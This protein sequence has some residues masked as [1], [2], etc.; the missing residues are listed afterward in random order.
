MAQMKSRN[1]RNR[2]SE[3][4]TTEEGEFEYPEAF[5]ANW[6]GLPPKVFELRRKLYRKAKSEPKFRFYALYDR[7]YRRDVLAAAWAQVS[8]NGGAPGVDGISIE[9]LEQKEGGIENLL[10]EIEEALRT[11]SYQ[12]QA[13]RR[14]YIPKADG[15][16]RPLGIPTV[17][18]RIVQ[19]AVLLVIEPVFEADFEETSYGFRPKRSAKHALEAIKAELKKGRRQV[20]DADLKACFDTI[21]HQKLLKCLENRIADRS[22]SGLIRMWLGVEVVEEDQ[23]GRQNRSRQKRGTPQGGVISPLLANIYL[24]WLDKLFRMESGPRVWADARIVRYADDF[25]ILTSRKTEEIMEWL[26]RLL[27]GRM[28]LVINQQKTGIRNVRIEGEPLDFLGYT[29]RW[30]KWSREW[31]RRPWLSMKPSKKAQQRFREQVRELTQ[32][33][34]C[35][36]PIPTVVGR[37]NA[38]LRGWRQYFNQGNRGKVFNHANQYV[39]DR[40]V[41]HLKRRSQRHLRPPG[42]HSYY[43]FVYQRLGVARL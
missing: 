24:H 2:L 34:Y 21:D 28:G 6:K 16:H 36:T 30:E 23:N 7:V 13:I 18:D 38:Y 20:V 29:L 17:R 10:K 5:K 3:M 11:K 27:E 31:S 4:T 8:R 37:L 25:V 41:R 40:M 15:G 42:D 14:V 43:Q 19:M 33:R 32:S 22:V 1:E 35:G 9:A 26:T 39:Y 12:P